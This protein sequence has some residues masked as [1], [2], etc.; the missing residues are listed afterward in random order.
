M[1]K[2]GQNGKQNITLAQHEER[3]KT[4]EAA[5]KELKFNFESIRNWLFFGF[6]SVIGITALLQVILRLFK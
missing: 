1:K 2:E 3:I 4:L 5:V 6:I